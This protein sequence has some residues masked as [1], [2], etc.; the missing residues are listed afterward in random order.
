MGQK[1]N[2]QKTKITSSGKKLFVQCEAVDGT[3]WLATDM[4]SGVLKYN[5]DKFVVD[6]VT[7]PVAG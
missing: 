7:S 3:G 4:S 5:D 2:S 6:E 1:N